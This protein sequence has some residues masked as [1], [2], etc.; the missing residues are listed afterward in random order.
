MKLSV[1]KLHF[2]APLHISN[3]REDYTTSLPT[4]S[5]DSMYSALISSL[6]K[7]GCEIP[8]NGDLGVTISSLFPFYQSSQESKAVLLFPKPLNTKFTLPEDPTKLKTLKKVTWLDKEYFEKVLANED[9]FQSE[10]DIKNIRGEYMV[11]SES[12]DKD[13]ISSALLSRVKVNRVSNEDEKPEPFDMERLHFSGFSGLYFLATGD[14]SILEKSLTFLQNEGLGTDRN[15]GNGYFVYIKDEIEL[16]TPNNCDYTLSLSNY[17]PSSKDEMMLMIGH[18]DNNVS[19]DITR[20]GGW[21]STYPYNSIRKN[22]IYA[23][24]PGSVLKI[25]T[26]STEIKGKIVNLA[27]ELNFEPKLDHPVWRCGK[28]I[29]IPIKR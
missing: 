16:V 17:I 29:L 21:I 4:I 25:S 18:N 6:A 22:T 5:S 1:Y 19:Y 9:I 15:A 11:K 20:I 23:F 12:F 13:F 10:K 27:P 8:E 24:I 28:A 7:L 2:T 3:N 14:C 26:S